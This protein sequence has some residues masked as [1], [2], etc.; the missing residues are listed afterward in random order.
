MG[1]C[2]VPEYAGVRGNEI[3]GNLA[4]DGSLQRFVGPEPSLGVCRQNIKINIKFWMDNQHLITWS[5][6]SSSETETGPSPGAKTRLLSFNRT[7][8]RVVIGRL[9]GHDTLRR[10]HHLMGL[11]NSPLCR[12]CGTEDEIS[13]TF[14]V[15]VKPWL[16]SDMH[17]WAPFPW[18]QK[19]LRV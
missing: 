6:L 11:T 15:R 16:R 8:S 1:L 10:H 4:R 12:R 2:W 7:Q 14:S 19:T 5:G 3:A 17:I 9:I 13:G 18:I